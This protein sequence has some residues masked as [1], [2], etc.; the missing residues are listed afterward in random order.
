[1]KGKTLFAILLPFL[2]AFGLG[3]SLAISHA[4]GYDGWFGLGGTPQP[5]LQE[6]PL[7]SLEKELSLREDQR[8]HFQCFRESCHGELGSCRS[9]IAEARSAL[10]AAIL[11]EPA[12]PERIE[13]AQEN[14]L[15]VYAECQQAMVDHILRLK[16]RLDPEQRTKLAKA[17][18]PGVEPGAGGCGGGGPCGGRCGQRHD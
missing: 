15:R 13:R 3:G 4:A 11:A 6:P 9:R 2:I 1:M 14:L 12:D 17:F 7:Q 5:E 18:F 16:D 10:G 8:C